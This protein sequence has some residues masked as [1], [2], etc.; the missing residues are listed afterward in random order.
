VVNRCIS[1]TRIR[2]A[3]NFANTQLIGPS[4]RNL[5]GGMRPT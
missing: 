5:P 3:A 4:S 1:G 2:R